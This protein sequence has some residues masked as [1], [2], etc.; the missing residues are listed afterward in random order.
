MLNLPRPS[1]A[2][3]W[4]VCSAS[5]GL[6]EQYPELDTDKTAAEEGTAAHWVAEQML[7]KFINNLNTYNPIGTDTQNDVVITNEMYDAALLYA[8]TIIDKCGD[9]IH[10]LHVEQAVTLDHIYPGM[11]GTPDAWY[12]DEVKRVLYI[13]DLKFGHVFVTEYQNPQLMIYISGILQQLGISDNEVLLSMNI[14]QP[15]HYGS[16]SVREWCV[17]ATAIR[18]FII[19]LE[20]AAHRIMNGDTTCVPGPHCRHCR[21]HVCNA[22]QD[23]IYNCVDVVTESHPIDL[24]GAALGNELKLLNH[25]AQLVKFRQTAIEQQ[26]ELNIKGGHFIPG[27]DI[28]PKYGRTAWKDDIDQKQVIMMGELMGVDLRKPEAL[29]TPT[30]AIAKLK[31]AKVDSNIVKQYSHRPSKGMKLTENNVDDLRNVNFGSNE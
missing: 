28:E 31:R 20:A 11:K 21:R 1:G 5:Q 9:N 26:V 12:Y 8:Q 13:W 30:Q 19:N 27:W 7:T 6:C 18:P 10:K 23:T 25:I 2:S 4:S 3:R 16:N 17:N 15:R 24:Q 29:D 14:I 22:I